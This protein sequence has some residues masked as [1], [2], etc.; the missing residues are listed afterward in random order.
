MKL[1]VAGATSFVA[2]EVIRQALQL[3]Q[4][5]SVV[6]LARRPVQ[7]P[8]DLP[9]NVDTSKLKN[10]V[11]E[12]FG[13]YSDQ[14]KTELR[15]TDAC[16]YCAAITP[17]QIRERGTTVAEAKQVC[18][19]YAM[20]LFRNLIESRDNATS[21]LRLTY[22]SGFAVTRDLDKEMNWPQ[23]MGPY[24]KMRGAAEIDVIAFANESNGMVEAGCVRPALI[25]GS[26]RE[27]VLKKGLQAFPNPQM[28][29]VEEVAAAMLN[30]S[31]HGFEKEPLL[32]DDLC[33]MGK[34]ALQDWRKEIPNFSSSVS[35]SRAE[36]L[37]LR[38]QL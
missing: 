15:Q 24:V 18:H 29:A 13:V 23:G 5:T 28:V 33:Q 2:T 6:A 34:Q 1:V 32:N 14:A 16:I 11:L 30:Q 36:V 20:I 19:D 21:P 8:P 37:S 3:P 22:M 35:P 17:S 10:V 27:D 9:A 26:K 4:V 7:P 31:M 38:D 25:I 12:D